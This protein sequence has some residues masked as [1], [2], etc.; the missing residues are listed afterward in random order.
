GPQR[1]RL[2]LG[3]LV[4]AAA[5]LDQRADAP[6]AVGAIAQQVEVADPVGPADDD[7]AYLAQ[8]G[9]GAARPRAD[10]RFGPADP[11]LL[12]V[13]RGWLQLVAHPV[14]EPARNVAALAREIE[15]R[16]VRADAQH[17]LMVVVEP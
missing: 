14:V 7:V 9:V 6:V 17:A 12:D 3:Q 1:R 4:E 15:Q 2:A 13:G 10:R 11:G 8:P 16:A 5:R